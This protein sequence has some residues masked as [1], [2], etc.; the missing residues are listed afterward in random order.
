MKR[1]KKTVH[2]KNTTRKKNNGGMTYIE[3]LVALSLLVLVVTMFSPML[4]RSYDSLYKAGEM[5]EFA[6][7]ARSKIEEGLSIRENDNFYNIQTNFEKL[8]DTVSIK[9]RQIIS[10][11]NGLETLYGGARGRIKVVSDSVVSDNQ[12]AQVVRLLVTNLD[13][14]KY[15]FKRAASATVAQNP[16]D[17]EVLFY[18]CSAFNDSVQLEYT[19]TEV[20][21]TNFLDIFI[22]DIN[23]TKGPIKFYAY[24]KDDFGVIKKAEAYL[25]IEPA[26][27]MFV[28]DSDSQDYFTS[29]GVDAEKGTFFIAGRQMATAPI[30]GEML[31]DVEWVGTEND[32]TIL[33]GY[34][35]MCG[36][37]SVVR[38]LWR[39]R[40]SSKSDNI[41]YKTT[42]ING[43]AYFQYD[44]KG[45][46]TDRY[47]HISKKG[48]GNSG[49]GT[50]STDED[51]VPVDKDVYGLNKSSYVF[52]YNGH[53][54]NWDDRDQMSKRISYIAYTNEDIATAAGHQPLKGFWSRFT[55][56]SAKKQDVFAANGTGSGDKPDLGY[57]PSD[58]QWY[59]R[60]TRSY[61]VYTEVWWEAT[62]IYGADNWINQWNARDTNNLPFNFRNG[63]PGGKAIWDATSG[64][65]NRT[66]NV[67]H[68]EEIA[69]LT[70]KIYN[71]FSKE[72]LGVHADNSMP[73]APSNNPVHLTSCTVLPGKSGDSIYFGRTH[74][75]ALIQQTNATATQDDLAGLFT[76]YP[77]ISQTG[78]DGEPEMRYN[79][80]TQDVDR[81]SLATTGSSSV[82]PRSE[83]GAEQ[84]AA[85]AYTNSSW[86]YKYDNVY[87]TMGYASDLYTL[88][89]SFAEGDTKPLEDSYRAANNYGATDANVTDG[90][91]LP[92]EFYNMVE[93]DSYGKSVVAVGYN[94]AGKVSV[95]YNDLYIGNNDGYDYAYISY[96]NGGSL[97][98]DSNWRPTSVASDYTRSINE[99]SAKILG[100]FT[101]EGQKYW[102]KLPKAVVASTAL[103]KV[104]NDGVLAV[105]NESDATFQNIYYYRDPNEQSVRF[106]CVS[107]IGITDSIV[108]AAIGLSDGKVMLARIPYNN[109]KLVTTTL[110]SASCSTFDAVPEISEITAIKNL[111]YDI[112]G[113][114]T[115]ENLIVAGGIRAEGKKFIL[116][117]SDINDTSKHY[118]VLLDEGTSMVKVTDIAVVNGYLYVSAIEN[119]NGGQK[120]VI[121]AVDIKYIKDINGK[122]NNA[123]TESYIKLTYK[124]VDGSVKNAFKKVNSY[125][126]NFAVDIDD[127]VVIGSGSSTDLPVINSIAAKAEQ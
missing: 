16:G 92:R 23:V 24:F 100:S 25:Y 64:H 102:I 79:A 95:N 12:D 91:W 20:A 109:G 66:E 49:F 73:A 35:L 126:T 42:A 37:N 45:D 71:N 80:H 1:L 59:E 119:R 88:Y 87:F 103:E 5:T 15:T 75:N 104:F 54:G 120:G 115:P 18:V 39:A 105:Y 121:Y 27:M 65:E 14:D 93:S 52:A 70:L 86:G 11:V 112:T 68:D 56:R 67:D 38:R 10:S 101:S 83:F 85:N 9:A 2:S 98:A 30:G 89:N 60:K 61:V 41:T 107:T 44:W 55:N 6:Y 90:I 51:G 22:K 53:A 76:A 81:V 108:G 4:L 29:A 36:E 94:F 21:E 58:N 62:G 57:N 69:Y 19:F 8:S 48:A 43:N 113:D 26:D 13:R 111:Q 72:N 28:G 122:A 74:A 114:G 33:D 82:Q 50:S 123:S 106:N 97:K 117:L 7:D 77:V 116:R 31:N 17:G 99:S 96:K 46:Y 3:L 110:T 34:Y 32:S 40:D 127:G 84:Y 78:S 47:S 118:K 63:V 125:Y 124:D